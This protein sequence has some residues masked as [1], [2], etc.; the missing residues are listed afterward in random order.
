MKKLLIL[1]VILVIVGVF[2][3]STSDAVIMEN[4]VTD[5]TTYFVLRDRTAGT[6]DTGV[7]ITNIDLYYTEERAA[8]STVINA[9]A[10]AAADSIHTDGGVFHCGHGVY[11][12]DWPDAAFDGGPRTKVQLIIVDGDAGAFTEILEIELSPSMGSSSPWW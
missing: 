12:V 6:V 7:T 2:F 9:T 10:L 8:E 5:V 4:Q 3:R 1:L 11:R